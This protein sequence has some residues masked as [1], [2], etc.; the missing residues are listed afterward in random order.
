MI[1]SS[2]TTTL[3]SVY[4]YMGVVITNSLLTCFNTDFRLLPG[5]SGGLPAGGMDR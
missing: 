5:L 3:Y 4:V 1:L 2:S